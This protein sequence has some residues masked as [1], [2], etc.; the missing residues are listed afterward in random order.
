MK[1]WTCEGLGVERD[2]IDVVDAQIDESIVFE[3]ENITLICLRGMMKP[4]QVITFKM[5]LIV[6]DP[7]RRDLIRTLTLRGCILQPCR[8]RLILEL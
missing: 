3:K 1:F 6:S 8:R 7:L 4:W 2:S 5:L